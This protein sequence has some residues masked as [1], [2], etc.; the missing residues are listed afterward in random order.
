MRIFVSLACILILA[1]AVAAQPDT[2]I[3]QTGT[4]ISVAKFEPNRVSYRKA[5]DAPLR[6]N[7]TIYDISV[8]TASRV[9][10]GRYASAID[11]LPSTLTKGNSVSVRI[12][13]HLMYLKQ[14]SGED[15]E[16]TV[17]SHHQTRKEK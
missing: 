7:G 4:I 9:V 13:K 8:Q 16:L 5:T 3:Y 2:R 6:S 11:Y 15:L 14:P 12:E 10:V 1:A 17:V